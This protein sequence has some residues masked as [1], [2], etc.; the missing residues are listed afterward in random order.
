MG[1]AR[2]APGDLSSGPHSQ[3]AN[4]DSFHVSP[5]HTPCNESPSHET[6][7]ASHPQLAGP[8]ELNSLRAIGKP[9]ARFRRGVVWHL[10]ALGPRN[11]SCTAHQR[12]KPLAKPA[13]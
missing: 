4:A 11:E 8:F 5:P 9:I 13:V 6:K 2:N 1:R 7:P 12:R 10:L 3:G